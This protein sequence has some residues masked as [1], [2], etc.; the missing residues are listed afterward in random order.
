MFIHALSLVNVV[1]LMSLL[2]G[3]TL[4]GDRLRRL[5]RQRFA[6]AKHDGGWL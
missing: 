2:W 5:C 6:A 4:C 3:G 1:G